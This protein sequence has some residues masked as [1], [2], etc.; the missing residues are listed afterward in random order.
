MAAERED[1]LRKEDAER[2][3]RHRKE[4]A[5]KERWAAEME[6]RRRYDLKERELLLMAQKNDEERESRD[7]AAMKGK[8]FG[9]A[10]HSA[11]IHM[12]PMLLMLFHSLKM[13][14]NCLQYMRFLLHYRLFLC[15]HF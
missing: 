11:A 4:E 7:S 2:V 12:G 6:E 10:M 15:D 5:E 9:D 14:S 13:L 3:K 8:V 1:R